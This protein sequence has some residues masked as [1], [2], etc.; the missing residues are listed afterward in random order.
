MYFASSVFPASSFVFNYFRRPP[1]SP[2]SVTV[3]PSVPSCASSLRLRPISNTADVESGQ[4]QHSASVTLRA[5]WTPLVCACS[6]AGGA[7]SPDGVPVGTCPRPDTC[8]YLEA[9]SVQPC[10]RVCGEPAL[11][12]A[13]VQLQRL[14]KKQPVPA[15]WLKATWRLLVSCTPSAVLRGALQATGGRPKDGDAVG[16]LSAIT[17]AQLLRAQCVSRGYW[18]YTEVTVEVLTAPQHV[19]VVAVD[20][21][22]WCARQPTADAVRQAVDTALSLRAI[23]WALPPAGPPAAAPEAGL[24]ASVW[25]AKAASGSGFSALH[26]GD[27]VPVGGHLL[28][29]PGCRCTDALAAGGMPAPSHDNCVTGALEVDLSGV[30]WHTGAAPPRLLLP[31]THSTTVEDVNALVLAGL[32]GLPGW[33]TD[34]SC[35]VL[36]FDG[37]GPVGHAPYSKPLAFRLRPAAGVQ[38]VE[39][40]ASGGLGSTGPGAATL[41]SGATVSTTATSSGECVLVVWASA[42]LLSHCALLLTH[43]H[44]AASQPPLTPPPPLSSLPPS[45]HHA[46][47]STFCRRACCAARSGTRA[48]QP[49]ER[50]RGGH[51]GSFALRRQPCTSPWAV[52]PLQPR[53]GSCDG[54]QNAAAWRAR[55]CPHTFAC[56][57]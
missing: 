32:T 1:V 28:F 2:Q 50:A 23:T 7:A 43:T 42:S 44:S 40:A 11:D 47:S 10:Q 13:F 8:P 36:K 56:S 27:E 52:P 19:L 30:P 4:L 33:T 14:S 21:G 5:K 49:H 53:G 17:H 45:L 39:A 22:S 31:L 41:S 55:E 20:T 35:R 57:L 51:W 26:P 46:A 16:W 3:C 54:Q 24:A 18:G 38:P 29:V 34:R 12:R 15:Q 37:S 6:P 25:A 48:P 9:A